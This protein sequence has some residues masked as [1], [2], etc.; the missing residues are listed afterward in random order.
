MNEAK[1]AIAFSPTWR[2]FPS[3]AFGTIC[4]FANIVPSCGIAPASVIDC[5]EWFANASNAIRSAR[6]PFVAGSI[7]LIALVVLSRGPW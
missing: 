4:L 6:I 5:R 3:A 7:L 1:E 2:F